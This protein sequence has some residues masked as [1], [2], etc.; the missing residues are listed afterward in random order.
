MLVNILVFFFSSELTG[1]GGD[2]EEILSGGAD[3]PRW[4]FRYEALTKPTSPL[5]SVIQDCNIEV[6]PLPSGTR[7]VC[8]RVITFVFK[9]EKSISSSFTECF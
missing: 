1:C 7:L 8:D 4:P 3:V 6:F 2:N 9:P 5:R